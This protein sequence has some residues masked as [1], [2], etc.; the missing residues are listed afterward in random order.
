MPEI[1]TAHVPHIQYDSLEDLREEINREAAAGSLLAFALQ[2]AEDLDAA[3]QRIDI[4]YAR[5]DDAA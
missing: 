1:T 5:L 4:A 3:Y 2:M